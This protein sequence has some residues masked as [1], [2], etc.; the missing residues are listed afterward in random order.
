MS[1][2]ITKTQTEVINERNTPSVASIHS[3]KYGTGKVEQQNPIMSGEDSF[4]DAR[5]L[6]NSTS[7]YPELEDEKSLAQSDHE[8]KL[9]SPEKSSHDFPNNGHN[10]IFG[11]LNIGKAIEKRADFQDD[12][13]ANYD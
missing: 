13:L 11:A 12:F 5:D 2:D 7:D 1:K 9:A 4:T 3:Q 8:Q 10:P 6:C